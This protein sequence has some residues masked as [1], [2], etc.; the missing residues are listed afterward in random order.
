MKKRCTAQ[1][2]NHPALCKQGVVWL[3]LLT[4]PYAHHTLEMSGAEPS[5]LS[6]G[7]LSFGEVQGKEAQVV[8]E[9]L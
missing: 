4:A 3:I 2:K 1:A 9:D 8:G 7:V 5:M 6:L